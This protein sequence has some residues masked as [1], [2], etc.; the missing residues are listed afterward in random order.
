MQSFKD[1]EETI[2]QFYK[3]RDAMHITNA[4]KGRELDER[5]ETAEI[6][7]RTCIRITEIR[8]TARQLTYNKIDRCG[9]DMNLVS[10]QMVSMNLNDPRHPRYTAQISDA[11]GELRA[12]DTVLK[13]T[14]IVTGDHA[15]EY[16]ILM[17]RINTPWYKSVMDELVAI[18]AEINKSLPLKKKMNIGNTPETHVAKY[19]RTLYLKFEENILDHK[20]SL[21]KQLFGD[22]Q[23]HKVQSDY[24]IVKNRFES[25]FYNKKY[26]DYLPVA[27]A[28]FAQFIRTIEKPQVQECIICFGDELEPFYLCTRKH[29][30]HKRCLAQ[31]VKQSKTCPYCRAIVDPKDLII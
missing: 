1:D 23:L 13:S 18:L 14:P 30:F 21:Q 31:W 19:A 25:E 27:H 4:E 29:I 10:L 7:I 26:A 17:I 15:E 9:Y 6:V 3:D 5:Y 28:A 20:L 2:A 22:E 11:L 8:K 16:R 24:E 12:L